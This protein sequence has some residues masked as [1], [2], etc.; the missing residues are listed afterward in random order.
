MTRRGHCPTP[1]VSRRRIKPSLMRVLAVPTGRSSMLGD[2]RV[3]VALEIGQ[4]QRFSLDLGQGAQRLPDPSCFHRGLRGLRGGVVLHRHVAL[5]VRRVAAGARLR[6]PHPVHRLAVHQRED[7]RDGAAAL[8]VEP[9]GRPPDLQEGFL[10]DLLGLGR[11]ADDADGEPVGPGRGGVVQ[12]AKAASS[13]RPER[14][15]SSARSGAVAAPERLRLPLR[16]AGGIGADAGHVETF[17][18]LGLT[19]HICGMRT[20]SM[21]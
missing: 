7:P 4:L 13:P 11:V 20:P 3:R 9:A 15:S 19:G 21:M 18:D 12:L 6:R 5:V 16:G 17:A 2:L 10:G 1:I 14:L 8:R